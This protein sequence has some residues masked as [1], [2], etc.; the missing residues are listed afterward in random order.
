MVIYFLFFFLAQW[1]LWRCQLHD[2]YISANNDGI[3]TP[4]F[5]TWLRNLE[6][7]KSVRVD[8]LSFLVHMA[9]TCQQK[10][11]NSKDIMVVFQGF[12]HVF[13]SY[14]LEKVTLGLKSAKLWRL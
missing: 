11:D 2:L 8:M 12:L 4:T 9:S 6:D 3:M 14:L 1:F 5:F 10:A 13:T 7:D